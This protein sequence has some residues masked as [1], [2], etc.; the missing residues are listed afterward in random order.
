MR[1]ALVVATVAVPLYTAMLHGWIWANRRREQAHLWLAVAALGVA[2]I[3]FTS[4]GRSAATPSGAAD[5]QH[6]AMAA[7]AL[8]LFGFIRWCHAFLGEA[9]PATE[10]LCDALAAITL[11]GAATESFFTDEFVMRPGLASTTL[12]P[13]AL[14]SPFGYAVVGGFTGFT[15]YIAWRLGHAARRSRAARAPFVAYCVFW[16]TLFHDVGVGASLFSA[17]MI[18]PFGYMAM[19]MG[20]S[21]ELFGGFVRSMG[22][23]QRAASDL[24][25]RAEEEGAA[26]RRKERQLLHG[27]RL[28]ALGTLAAG[29]AH[30]INDPLAFVS[31]NLNRVEESWSDP[32]ERR[33]VPEILNECHEGLA[34][35]RGT[36]GELLR[37]ARRR[38]SETVPID[39]VEVV[40]SVLPLVRAEGRFRARWTEFLTAVPEVR[41]D[42]GLLAQVALQLLLN[43]LR[44]IPE[45]APRHHRIHVATS[46]EGGR[47][48]LR[49][50]DSGP[51]IPAEE[52]PHL[53]DPFSPMAAGDDAPRLGLAVTHQIV[54]SH[55]GEIEIESDERGTEVTVWLP[56][57]RAAAIPRA[58][59]AAS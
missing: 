53:F 17:P 6:G 46:S 45:G 44:S 23:A 33:E 22:A 25:A 49:V 13:Q 2:G 11:A 19:L 56:I 28:A 59:D 31:S 43:A 58:S 35:L 57:A 52:L 10:R 42:P 24:T 27:E 20:M 50:R 9:R 8:L 55:G 3:A 7:G 26:L 30:E 34:R 21:A 12:G 39:L 4:V 32:R 36:V 5:W 40:S 1:N 29:V 51:P 18:L 48:C 38:E 47:V 14:L 16:A 37:L 41:G 54:T 15:G